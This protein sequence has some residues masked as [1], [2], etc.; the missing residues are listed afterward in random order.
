M[1]VVYEAEHMAMRR[2]AAIKVLRPEL[3][4]DEP[5]DPPLLQRGARR[6]T[7]SATRHRPDLRLRH[8]R[9]R[10]RY[11]V[12]ELLEGETLARRLR[13]P[14]RCR[15]RTAIAH[16]RAGRRRALAA[17]HARRHRPPRPQAREH[18]P[19]RRSAT[20]DAAERVKVLD[21]GIAKL[22]GS[23]DGRRRCARRPARCIGTPLY[24]SPEQCRG[25]RQIDARSDIYSLG[26]ILYQMTRASSPSC[27]RG[28]A[29]C[30]T[31]R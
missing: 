11:I 19:R 1:G 24:M 17:A 10:R 31:C 6:P 3:A 13:A 16:R 30:S 4:R 21:F 7:R 20:A 22:T 28:S 25:T 29:S 15:R 14:A 8:A 27:P 18:V 2:R 5:G 12:M 23:V 9:G 26:L